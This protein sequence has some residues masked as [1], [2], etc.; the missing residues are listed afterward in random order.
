MKK[1]DFRTKR[2]AQQ[3]ATAQEHSDEITEYLSVKRDR[4]ESGEDFTR[5]ARTEIDDFLKE[6]YAATAKAR[7]IIEEYLDG[8]END[9]ERH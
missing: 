1:T 4:N 9:G 6:Q 2:K 3:E 8:K 5:R 7:E